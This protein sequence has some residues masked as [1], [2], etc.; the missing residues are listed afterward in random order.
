M[1]FWLVLAQQ[2]Q[3]SGNAGQHA[4]QAGQGG[5]SIGEAVAGFI[6]DWANSQY[7]WVLG[8]VILYLIFRFLFRLAR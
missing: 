6:S 8:A 4:Q 3:P 2:A 5:A 7:G 1:G